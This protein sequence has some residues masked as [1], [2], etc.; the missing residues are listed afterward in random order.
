MCLCL[1]VCVCVCM[2]C[3]RVCVLKQLSGRRVGGVKR[4]ILMRPSSGVSICLLRQAAG[5]SAGGRQGCVCVCVCV[6]VRVCVCV[7]VLGVVKD[8]GGI[9]GNWRPSAHKYTHTH[10]QSAV[11]GAGVTGWK[12]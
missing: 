2:F 8:K 1:C 4:Q 11:H 6:C 12:S 5:D 9:R 7:C 10:T 3:A